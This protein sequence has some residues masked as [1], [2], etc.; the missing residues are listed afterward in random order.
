MHRVRRTHIAVFVVMATL[1]LAACAHSRAAEATRWAHAR[2]L[3]LVTIDDWNATHGTL[4]RY[5]RT[6]NGEWRAVDGVQ[7]VVIGRAGA[8]WGLGLNDRPAGGPDKREGDG[9]S[10]A[11]VFAIG[12]A[13]GYAPHG[14]TGLRYDAMDA[15]D[16]CI[17]SSDSPLYNRIVDTDEAGAGVVRQST[18]PMRRDLHAGGDQRYRLGFVIAHNAQAVP[19]GGSCIFGH[20]WQSPDSTTTGCTAMAPDTMQALLGWLDADRQPIFV[21]L[22]R[23][24]YRRRWQAWALPRPLE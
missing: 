8:A 7:P 15:G 6:A 10:P 22:P 16:Y 3:V 1:A 9:R 24:E 14:D 20:L 2:Q 13:F 18:E 11:G 19:Q 17:D 12:D 5:E 4:R 23:A 21:L